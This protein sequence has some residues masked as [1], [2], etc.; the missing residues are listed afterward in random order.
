M[1]RQS[2]GIPNQAGLHAAHTGKEGL[3][4]ATQSQLDLRKTCQRFQQFLEMFA[5]GHAQSQGKDGFTRAE[6]MMGLCSQ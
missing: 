5:E 3:E 6:Q 2:L 4:G 1:D